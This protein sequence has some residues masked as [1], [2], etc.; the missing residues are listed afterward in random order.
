MPAVQDHL[1]GVREV[2][3]VHRVHQ[4]R[5]GP[6]LGDDVEL[7]VA[8]PAG[9]VEVRRA[10]PRPAPV[11]D[12]RLPDVHAVA[13]GLH[14]R[15]RA[16]I[17]RVRQ[18]E[19]LA[20][21][22]GDEVIH[23]EQARE[24]RG[25]GDHAQSRLPHGRARL[26]RPEAGGGDRRAHERPHLRERRLDLEDGRAA[27]L[28]ASIS[29]RGDAA[30]GIAD[31]GPADAETGH[32]ADRAVDGQHLAVVPAEPPEGTGQPGSIVAAHLDPARA[33]LVPDRREVLPN[34]PIQS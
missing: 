13:R 12:R 14:V 5:E 7:V 24:V 21:E 9:H 22:G 15:R 20:R 33:E 30:R 32:E 6:I 16:G 31:P 27:D 18:P 10:H 25:R 8:E 29:P 11:R 28:D 17:V 4:G 1:G 26:A 23:A 3:Q 34:A 19:P 2:V